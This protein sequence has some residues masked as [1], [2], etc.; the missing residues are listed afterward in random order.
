MEPEISVVIPLYNCAESIPELHKR[1]SNVFKE[2]HISYEIVFVN[3]GSV[4][5]DWEIVKT[6]SKN[7]Q[8]IKGISFD[9][10]YGQYNAI[11]CGIKSAAGNWI[12]VMDGDLQDN[13]EEIVKLYNKTKEGYQIVY[14]LRKGK[15]E[16]FIS[17]IVSFFYKKIM[18]FIL[19]VKLNLDISN[20][21]IINRGF[22]QEVQKYSDAYIK[23]LPSIM[24]FKNFR[25][26]QIKVKHSKRHIGKSSYNFLKKYNL[27]FEIVFSFSRKRVEQFFILIFSLALFSSVFIGLYFF[28]SHHFNNSIN[29]LLISLLAM[30]L[31]T[32]LFAA[33]GINKTIKIKKLPKRN[34]Y[35]ISETINF[36]KLN[37]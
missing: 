22:I 18:S 9:K 20:F 26:A 30:A 6:L 14:A 12:V 17:N 2:L 4:Q 16:G 21:C 28:Q 19:G 7:N 24:S 36:D 1:L 31:S 27:G 25:S 33:S 5:N 34:D 11:A 10:N 3:D 29:I 13:P 37:N 15:R 35:N 23:F 32:M 8:S